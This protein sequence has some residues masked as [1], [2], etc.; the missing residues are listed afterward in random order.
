VYY[1]TA[2]TY[3]SSA[4]KY[5]G[6]SWRNLKVCKK[7]AVTCT[8]ATSPGTCEKMGGTYFYFTDC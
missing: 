5:F 4:G 2:G 6:V 8:A 1:T 3:C 7:D